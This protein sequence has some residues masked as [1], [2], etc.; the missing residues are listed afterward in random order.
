MTDDLIA[1]LRSLDLA[2][3][4]AAPP[5]EVADTCLAEWQATGV[6]FAAS[7]PGMERQ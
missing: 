1:G 2:A 4:I 6:A 3:E 5:G 7:D